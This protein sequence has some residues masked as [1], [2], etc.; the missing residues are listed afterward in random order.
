MVIVP[1]LKCTGRNARGG[2]YMGDPLKTTG[3]FSQ[4]CKPPPSVYVIVTKFSQRGQPFV[5]MDPP[6]FFPGGIFPPHTFNL[7]MSKFNYY[8][9]C[10][11]K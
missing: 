8:Y 7:Q 11:W 5:T 1:F 3:G 10:I 2:N 4:R 9:T 6:Q